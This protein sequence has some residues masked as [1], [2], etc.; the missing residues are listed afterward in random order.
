MTVTATWSVVGGIVGRLY[1]GGSITN[2]ANYGTV[3]T[4]HTASASASG[5]YNY[6]YVG[7]IVGQSYGAVTGCFNAA[8]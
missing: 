6:S 2:C 8:A 5:V 4:S 3:S 7:G 1:T